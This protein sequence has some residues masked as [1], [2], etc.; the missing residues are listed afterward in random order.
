MDRRSFTMAHLRIGSRPGMTLV[1]T[2][3]LDGLPVRA[4]LNRLFMFEGVV[5]A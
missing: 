4:E 3:V 2:L 1:G 5:G